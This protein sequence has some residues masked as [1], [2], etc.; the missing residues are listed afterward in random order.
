MSVYLA[1]D[2][3]KVRVGVAVS[4]PTG[5]LARPLAT[6]PRKPHKAFLEAIESLVLEHKATALVIGKP[7]NR[8]GKEGPAAQRSLS[9]AYELKTLL[10]IPAETLDE[11]LSTVEAEEIMR[12]NKVGEKDRAYKID[13]VSAA[14]I[15]SRYLDSKKD[16]LPDP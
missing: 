9:L 3:G 10:N 1:L 12:E 6:I 16:R 7:L 14:V 4:D 2:P 15:L 11:T 13:S 8:E 5:T